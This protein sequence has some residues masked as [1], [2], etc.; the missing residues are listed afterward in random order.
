MAAQWPRVLDR[1]VVILNTLPSWVDVQ[2]IDGLPISADVLTDCVTVGYVS[3]DN[4]GNYTLNQDPSGFQW[5]E[6]GVIR[7]ELSCVNGDSNL[8]TM[9]ARMFGLL[10][11]L[12]ESVRAD[13]TLGGVLSPQ[14]TAEL[15]VDVRSVQ[16]ISGA[17][18]S[19]VFCRNYTTIT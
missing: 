3:D 15:V 10:D 17:E 16:D 1:L 9:R 8:A 5:V 19:V 13:R 12:E 11:A 7:S 4:S 14:G 6:V 18:Q 2:V